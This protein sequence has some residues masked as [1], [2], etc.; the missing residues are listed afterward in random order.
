M[1]NSQIKYSAS[2][3]KISL[4]LFDEKK[5]KGGKEIFQAEFKFTEFIKSGLRENIYVPPISKSSDFRF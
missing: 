4:V 2:P 1:G 3:L 5:L